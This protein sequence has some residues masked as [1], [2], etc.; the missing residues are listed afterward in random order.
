MIGHTL[1][2]TSGL[3]IVGLLWCLPTCTLRPGVLVT[4]ATRETLNSV[5]AAVESP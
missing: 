2:P 1:L 3:V 5:P 4:V